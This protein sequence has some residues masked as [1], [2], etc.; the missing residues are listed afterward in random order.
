MSRNGIF[1][2]TTIAAFLG[3]AQN[4]LALVLLVLRMPLIQTPLQNILIFAAVIPIVQLQISGGCPLAL[5]E[6]GLNFLEPT[7][8]TASFHKFLGLQIVGFIRLGQLNPVN[9]VHR[10]IPEKDIL[11]S[12][13]EAFTDKQDSPIRGIFPASAPILDGQI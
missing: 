3:G 8:N 5:T 1:R 2:R 11:C 10:S 9:Y 7:G 13:F 6:N 12:K 4:P